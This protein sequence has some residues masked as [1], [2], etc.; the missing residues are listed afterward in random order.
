[1]KINRTKLCRLGIILSSVIM[2]TYLVAALFVAGD[3]DAHARCTG[4]RIEV[5]EA[6]HRG[7]VT[8]REI[9]RELHGLPERSAGMPLSAINTEE[10]TR[11]LSKIDKIEDVTVTRLSDGRIN[12][13]ITPLVPVARIFDGPVSYYINKVG[14]RI[15]ANARYHSDVPVIAGHFAENDTVFTP[16]SLLPLLDWLA[17]HN[18]TWG[19]FITMVKVDS[20]SDIILIPAI[21][22]HVINFGTPTDLDSKFSRLKTMYSKVLPVKGWNYYD[23]LSV[24]WGG[25]VVATRRVKPVVSIA[26]DIDV[27]EE[28]ADISTMLAA[29]G[30]AP[31]RTAPGQKAHNDKPIPASV[32][33]AKKTDHTKAKP[34]TV[35]KNSQKT[36]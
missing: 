26:G 22:G 34:D 13:T 30:V 16:A 10:I 9:A 14:K 20:P 27:D 35:T 29:E 6:S 11:E 19:R 15:G 33:S 3:A 4:M 17:A 36:K 2:A 21:S 31:G 25:Q 32:P 24:K 7:F 18:D 12:I 1:M 8:A 23:S 5:N 28:G